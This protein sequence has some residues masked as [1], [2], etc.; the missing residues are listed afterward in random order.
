MPTIV[1]CDT[2]QDLLD[3][4]I[5]WAQ[6]QSEMAAKAV[7]Q[8]NLSGQTRALWAARTRDTK[9]LRDFLASI[10]IQPRTTILVTPPAPAQPDQGSL[11]E[12]AREG[13]SD[14]KMDR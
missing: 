4:L 14:A 2:P 10:T 9:E 11:Y 8:P 12:I 7:R 6:T 1:R 13:A 3:A 5:I